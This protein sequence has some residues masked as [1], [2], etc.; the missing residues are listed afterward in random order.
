MWRRHPHPANPRARPTSPDPSELQPH[1]PPP[2]VKSP[3]T[4]P[5]RDA[6]DQLGNDRNGFSSRHGCPLARAVPLRLLTRRLRDVEWLLSCPF[7]GLWVERFRGVSSTWRPNSASDNQLFASEG[8]KLVPESAGFEQ[9][10]GGV[11]REVPEPWNRAAQMLEPPVNGLGGSVG[12]VWP[13][14]EGE[15]IDCALL[16]GTAVCVARQA[17]LVRHV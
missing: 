12:H 7:Q 4:A 14:R 1:H 5:G 2:P 13:I 10:S 8:W 16:Q 17:G 3:F 11:A 6:P 15:D 9:C